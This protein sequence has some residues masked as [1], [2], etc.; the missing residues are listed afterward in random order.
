MPTPSTSV[1]ALAA[2]AFAA[3]LTA[4]TQQH[5]VAPSAYATNDAIA[6]VWLPGASQLVRQ[7]TLVGT[8]HLAPLLG[9][10][11]TALEFRRTAWNRVFYGGTADMTVTLSIAPHGPLG[12]STAFA[13]NVGA[14]AVQVYSGPVV[15]PT[16]PATPD[17]SPTTA[18]PWS[19]DNVVRIPFTQPFLYLGGTLCI[20]ITGQPIAGQ[21]ANWWM[22]DA[23]FED[24]SGTVQDLGGGCGVYGGPEHEWSYVSP[25]SL[26]PGGHAHFHAYGTPWGLA[27]AAFGHKSPAGIPLAAFG[28]AAPPGCNVHLASVD[29]LLAGI[30]VPDSH[31]LLAAA[32]GRA[33]I[34]L[35]IPA[36]TS[37]FG[38]SFTTQWLDWAQPAVSNAIEW[39]VASVIPTLD[40]ALVDGHPAEARGNAT[41]H[42][43]HVLRFEYQ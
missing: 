40:M 14:P 19:I 30:F 10:T 36:T 9:R 7:Q 21:N 24:I 41:V 23:E 38:L 5:V 31:P 26:L 6:F 17:P 32:G 35:K 39:T 2:I 25:R 8:S 13:A 28:F 22:A 16:S 20:D 34:E 43:A 42:L 18:I 3:A 27:L 29:M 12:C 33:D 37:V 15:F 11:L 4:Q 1:P